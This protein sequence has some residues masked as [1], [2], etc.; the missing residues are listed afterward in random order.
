MWCT[1]ECWLQE[2]SVPLVPKT[3]SEAS[4]SAQHEYARACL[5]N[6]LTPGLV[7]STLALQ[8]VAADP[9]DTQEQAWQGLPA[10]DSWNTMS[11]GQTTSLQLRI[12]A[13]HLK[14]ISS[15]VVPGVDVFLEV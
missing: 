14:P 2:Y 9:T 11:P 8:G 5:R 3:V 10:A 6:T 13:D 15:A 1:K 4:L 12:N 7:C